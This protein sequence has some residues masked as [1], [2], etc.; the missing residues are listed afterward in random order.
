M[1]L[2]GILP[3]VLMALLMM[4]TVAYLRAQEQ[5]GA[6]TS[7]SRP[8]GI[9]RALMELG[10]VIVWPLG[11]WALVNKVALPAQPV[12]FGAIVVLFALDRYSAFRP[13][14]RS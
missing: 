10:L 4:V 9:G 3:G 8:A 6:A 13:C 12:V 2:A 5:A 1:F 14:C 11:T 7:S